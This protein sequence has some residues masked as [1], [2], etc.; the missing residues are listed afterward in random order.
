MDDVVGVNGHC[1]VDV[2]GALRLEEPLHDGDHLVLPR[3]TC[4]FCPDSR[5]RLKCVGGIVMR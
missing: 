2:T 1:A 3:L 4:S 5:Y